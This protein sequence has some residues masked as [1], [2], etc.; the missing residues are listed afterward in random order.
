MFPI[1]SNF[2]LFMLS[3][4]FY[5]NRSLLWT[6]PE[7]FSSFLPQ[8]KSYPDFVFNYLQKYFVVLLL[9]YKYTKYLEIVSMF[10]IYTSNKISSTAICSNLASLFLSINKIT[11]FYMKYIYIKWLRLWL[12]CLSFIYHT[13]ISFTISTNCVDLFA[14]PLLVSEQIHFLRSILCKA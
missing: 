14:I 5:I 3:I 12:Y 1:I 9:I 7:S 10:K 6:H 4:M 11:Y 13:K 8:R 2:H